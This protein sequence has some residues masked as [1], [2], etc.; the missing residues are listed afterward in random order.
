M[1]E[2]NDNNKVRQRG[3]C[4][5][6]QKIEKG[7]FLVVLCVL[8]FKDENHLKKLELKT[9]SCKIQTQFK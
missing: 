5:P 8:Y 6:L 3:K 7:D 9:G 2:K 4:H 1:V